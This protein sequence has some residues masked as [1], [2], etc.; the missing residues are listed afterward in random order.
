M[1]RNLTL[2]TRIAVR[3]R[4]H[5]C[6]SQSNMESCDLSDYC[7]LLRVLKTSVTVE[8]ST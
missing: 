5:T 6:I 1:T 3:E 2:C 4:Q 8:A 7:Y